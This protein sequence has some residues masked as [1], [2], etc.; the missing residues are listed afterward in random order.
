M[1][2]NVWEWC[3][4]EKLSTDT[5][6]CVHKGG[7]WYA[8]EKAA[9]LDARYGNT[10]MHFS[11][12]VGF[13]VIFPLPSFLTQD[14]ILSGQYKGKAWNG[15]AQNIPGTLECEC[16]D[17]GGEGIAFHDAD[18]V[19][20]GSGRLNPAN[21]TYL[22]E[23]RMNE[24]VDISYTK[25]KSIDDNPF[26]LVEPVMEK[27]YVGWTVPGEWIN[28]SINVNQSGIYTIGILYTA[29]GNGSIGLWLD[30][31]RITRDLIIPSTRNLNET[32]A[33]RQW[34]HWNRIDTLTTCR[35]EKGKHIL[36]LQ[37]LSNGNMN[38]DN[39]SFKLKE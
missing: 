33:W 38:Y 14:F 19:N 3:Y 25:S 31:K 11:N 34:H 17:L 30:G 22:N 16:Y 39:L 5:G 23:F 8:G 10:P 36:T 18:S 1:S 35:L 13:R 9:Q 15:K 2:G 37:T 4:N 32:I 28:Y 12:S 20:N 6:F 29:S 24:G 26:N 21:G 7:S 27:L